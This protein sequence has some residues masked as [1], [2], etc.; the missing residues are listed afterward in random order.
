MVLGI[1]LSSLDKEPETKTPLSRTLKGHDHQ[2]V[3][4]ALLILVSSKL[5]GPEH[6]MLFNKAPSQPQ[7]PYII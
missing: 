7:N 6:A 4:R 5:Y 2:S 1:F 3:R